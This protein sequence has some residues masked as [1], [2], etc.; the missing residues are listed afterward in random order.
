VPGI[1]G[2]GKAVEIAIEEQADEAERLRKL[3]DELWERLQDEIDGIKLNGH[4]EKRLPNNLNIAIPDIEAQA[5][6]VQMKGKIAI[7][8]GSACTT[9]KV[10]PSH[11][12][13][14]LSDESIVFSSI[15]LGLGRKTDVS[16]IRNAVGIIKKA[17]D[18]LVKLAV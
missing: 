3:R 11:V 9:G 10:E 16:Q 18:R 1:V 14:E 2:F 8:R 12:I 15:R 5:L 7:S 4:S 6:V 17:I 13:S